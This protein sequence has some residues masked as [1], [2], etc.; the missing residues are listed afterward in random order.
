LSEEIM[1]KKTLVILA[2]PNLAESQINAAWRSRLEEASG[3][4]TIRNIY[5]LYPDWNIDVAA[6]QALLDS[7][8]RIFLQFPVY[9]YS[10]PPLLKKWLD[11]VLAYGWAYGPGGD[12]LAHKEIGLV[13]STGSP[14]SAYQTAGRVGHT[15]VELLRPLEQTVR[16][17]GAR[18]LP[19]FALQGANR[20]IPADRL[21]RSANDYLEHV[22]A[23]YEPPERRSLLLR[24]RVK[25]DNRPAR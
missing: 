19:L 10:T 18:Y 3:P 15:L 16:F 23:T 22:R 6:E 20:L 13:V 1:S 17:V 9:W 4:I 12:H 11:E 2:H 8:E 24:E 21:E 14:E 5:E 25:P 7:H